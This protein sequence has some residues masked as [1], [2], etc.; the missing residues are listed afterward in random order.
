[1]AILLR[2]LSISLGIVICF[3]NITEKGE[4][5][6]NLPSKYTHCCISVMAKQ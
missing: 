6:E 5:Y 2:D 3:K 1:M 4:D